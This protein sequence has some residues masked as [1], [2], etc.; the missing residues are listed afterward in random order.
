[1]RYGRDDAAG[2]TAAWAGLNRWLMPMVSSGP[3]SAR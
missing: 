2:F 1:M 3:A